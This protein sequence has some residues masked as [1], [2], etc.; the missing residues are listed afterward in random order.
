MSKI[1]RRW[2]RLLGAY[3]GLKLEKYSLPLGEG[4][5]LLGAYKGLK[6]LLQV[7]ELFKVVGLLGAYKGLK[8]S[9]KKLWDIV[10]KEFIRCL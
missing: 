8:R 3:K 5:C 10:A 4:D 6:Q 7:F 1:C 2:C 9:T